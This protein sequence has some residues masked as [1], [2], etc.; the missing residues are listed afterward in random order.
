M[1]LVKYIEL[2]P[3]CLFQS[4]ICPKIIY[5][6]FKMFLQMRLFYIIFD[7]PKLKF[8]QNVT[9]NFPNPSHTLRIPLPIC[10]TTFSLSL[11]PLLNCV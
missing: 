5:K 8:D 11:K 10:L 3:G 9:N 7:L 1:A 4:Y 6:I 2:N